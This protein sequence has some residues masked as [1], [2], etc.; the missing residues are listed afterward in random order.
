MMVDFFSRLAEFEEKVMLHGQ[1]VTRALLVLVLGLLVTKFIH[2]Y[3]RIGLT[4]I[5]LN[6]TLISVIC[7]S[8]HILMLV[9]VIAFTLEQL[10]MASAVVY[11]VLTNISIGVIGVFIIFRPYLPTLPFKPGDQVE[12]DDYL[13]IIE[14]TSFLHTRLRTFDGRTIYI[15]NKKVMVETVTNYDITEA[16]QIRLDFAIGYQE[17]IARVKKVLFEVLDE[18]PRIVKKHKNKIFVKGFGESG[19]KLTVRFWVKNEDYWPGRTSVTE[20]VKAQLDQEGIAI[21]FPQRAIHVYHHQKGDPLVLGPKT[22]EIEGLKEQISSLQM[23]S[24]EPEERDDVDE[25]HS[26]NV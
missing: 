3:L 11:R 15:P 7:Q 9:V 6:R 20:K 1:M 2:K 5:N 17:D 19:I 16:R 18:D 14:S 21:Q 8:L 22:L 26:D 25:G 12:V 4:K 24:K 10:G 13:G 23:L